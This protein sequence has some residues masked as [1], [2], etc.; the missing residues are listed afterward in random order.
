MSV[1]NGQVDHYC[2]ITDS[3]VVSCG[4]PEGHEELREHLHW[5]ARNLEAQGPDALDVPD[6]WRG[7]KRFLREQRYT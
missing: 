6:G 4:C 7:L 3:M 1:A 5:H 2:G